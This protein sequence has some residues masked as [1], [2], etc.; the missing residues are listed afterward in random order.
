MHIQPKHWIGSGVL[1]T[2]AGLSVIVSAQ[3]F[4]SSVF[5]EANPSFAM[6]S[7]P[8]QGKTSRAITI[9]VIVWTS[10]STTEVNGSISSIRT[11]FF[12]GPGTG[13]HAD[14]F[15][16]ISYGKWNITGEV[17]G[18]YSHHP[19][20]GCF[21]GTALQSFARADG[22]V[23]AN[24]N[25][26]IYVNYDCVATYA[27][28]TTLFW[29][30]ATGHHS[31]AVLGWNFG[32]GTNGRSTSCIDN[33]THVY[34]TWGTTGVTC[35]DTV[36]GDLG[37]D[38]QGEELH[39][40]AWQK[41]IAGLLDP[42]NTWIASISGV[43]TIAPLETPTA[44]VLMLTLQ[45]ENVP[46]YDLEFRQ[47]VGQDRLFSDPNNDFYRGVIIHRSG[48]GFHSLLDGSP[49]G[50]VENEPTLTIGH[51]FYDSGNGV[52]VT[53]L[54]VSPTGAQVQVSFGFLDC[55][56]SNPSLTITPSTQVG[57]PGANLLYTASITNTDN[58]GCSP[59]G[60]SIT[61]S[62]P[63]GFKQTPVSMSVAPGATVAA[64]LNVSS[65]ASST[66]GAYPFT[67][68]A[69][70]ASA[71]SFAGSSNASV[72][73]QNSSASG[74]FVKQDDTTQSNWRGV[75]GSYGYAIPAGAA[76]LPSY[77]EVSYGTASV[78]SNYGVW[79]D[80]KPFSVDLRLTD[81]QTHQV[82]IYFR[83]EDNCG[84]MTSET[85]EVFDSTQSIHLDSRV[86]TPNNNY[87]MWNIRGHVSIKFSNASNGCPAVAGMF[88]DAVDGPKP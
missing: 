6:P 24:Y 81:G 36:F 13:S 61:G 37:P 10:T 16:E 71:T 80:V 29:P 65:A 25:Y 66:M 11:G 8:G 85:V 52:S 50:I 43:Y 54:N 62:L 86:I 1:A 72:S 34:V 55:V 9:A 44:G 57:A 39:Y 40:P 2:L 28:S 74:L 75:Y 33:A 51:T 53:P 30:G 45:K 47:P 19:E 27:E 70:N 69:T 7:T 48:A 59:S 82:A 35:T 42:S 67:A 4:G 79:W 60:F 73:V 77:A 20:I 63:A 58:P 17:Y 15:G 56:H 31:R 23:A 84:S 38:G 87:L 64:V 78:S 26:T 5:S 88:V 18:Y 3:H 68:T 49:N 22:Y 12:G 32:I 14:Y 76:S 21:G 41:Q 46:L 83:V